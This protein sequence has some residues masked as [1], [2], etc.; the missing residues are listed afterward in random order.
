MRS[1]IALLLIFCLTT[2]CHPFLP[3]ETLD[4]FSTDQLKV[5]Q[6]L[7]GALRPA[8]TD[9]G[10]VTLFPALRT[11]GAPRW[12]RPGTRVLYNFA[13]ATFARNQD[14]P[15]PSGG[16]LIEYD[17][18]AQN[19]RNVVFIS[20]L[21]STDIQGIVATLWRLLATPEA[22]AVLKTGMVLD[23]DRVTG[24]QLS[25]VQANRQ[26]VVLA[27]AGQGHLT[28]LYYDARDGKLVG[29]YMEEHS[30]AATRMTSLE[31]VQ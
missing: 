21:I 3:A 30:P 31:A 19:R 23:Q 13:S 1:L 11:A 22:I 18:V 5:I 26:Q 10:F 6:S 15:T 17:V 8:T 2:A 27:A 16:G 25:V 14:D 7:A 20:T 24:I 28:Q 9:T 29:I 12:L 4:F